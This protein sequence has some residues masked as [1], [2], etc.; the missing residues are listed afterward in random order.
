MYRCAVLRFATIIVSTVYLSLAWGQV[1]IFCG[2]S[3]VL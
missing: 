3:R 1:A 2:L